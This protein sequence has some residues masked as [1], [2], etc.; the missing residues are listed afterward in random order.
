MLGGHGSQFKHA[1]MT[2]TV[3]LNVK[4]SLWEDKALAILKRGDILAAPTE[5]VYGLAG[6]ATS[7]QAVRAIFKAK[8]RPS[9][10][11]LIAHIASREMADR[12][13]VL[14]PLAK[15]LMDAFWPG[16]LTVVVDA[17]PDAGLVPE[18]SAGLSSVALRCPHG[19]IARLSALLD[20]PLAAP[21]ANRSGHVS[22]TTAQHVADDLDG[23]VDLILDGGPTE[24][25]LESTIVDAR[26]NAPVLL[27]PG[28]V[29][30]A[31]I[32]AALGIDRLARPT[33][34]PNHPQAPGMLASHYAPR[35][36]LRLNAFEVRS[37]EAWLGFGAGEPD[38]VQR[39]VAR[40][41]LS[42]KGD[43]DEAARSL[44]GALRDLDASGAATI[45]VAPLPDDGIGAALNDRLAR[46]AAPRGRDS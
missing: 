46:A 9:H 17:Q 41:N 26:G 29:D 32:C 16:A 36:D 11:P 5:T 8:G 35:A 30:E 43:L 44:Y 21:S 40:A 31:A 4:G 18:A 22:A 15:T 28:A 38:D 19:V 13:G 42:R 14:T 3:S 27:R 7:Q 12:Y 2:E 24:M 20:A 10:N 37:G 25:G 23:K 1:I 33:A 39:A 6:D 34:N 45:A